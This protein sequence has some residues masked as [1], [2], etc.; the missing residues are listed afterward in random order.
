MFAGEKR[1][2][3]ASRSA[4]RETRGIILSYSGGIVES[5]YASNAQVSAE[6]HGHLGASMSQTGAERL[7]RQG[8]PFNAILGRYYAGASLARLAWHD[9]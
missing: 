6:A 2:N 8:L 4:T 3:T 5:L 1:T 9:Q 7:A